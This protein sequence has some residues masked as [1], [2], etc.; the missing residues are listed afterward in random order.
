MSSS[1]TLSEI[2]PKEPHT[3]PAIW[4]DTHAHL[5]DR[6]LRSQLAAVL[7]RA[8]GAGVAQVVAIGTTADDSAQLAKI[9][10]DQPGVFAAVG[11]HPNDAAEASEQDWASIRQLVTQPYVVA[12]GET[13]LDRYWDRTP[14]S[15]QQVWFERHLELAHNHDLPVVIHCRDCQRDIIDHLKRQGHPIKGVMHSFTGTSEDAE[16]FLSLGLSISFAGMVT[17]TNKALDALRDVARRVP[18]DRLL[19]ETDS[20][21][22]SPHPFR[23]QPNEPARVAL[24][25]Q[26][27]AQIHGLSEVEFARITTA[28]ARRL[29]RLTAAESLPV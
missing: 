16:A 8:S 20:P 26:R 13:G 29:F 21:Y 18:V 7:L 15:L 22:L 12:V 3:N 9:A 5:G 1:P 17:F 27:L 24:T 23:G 10:Q 2:V 28:N 6:R 14:F 4:V 11:I 19:V 25:G